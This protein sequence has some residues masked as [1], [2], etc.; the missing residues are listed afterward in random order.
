[1]RSRLARV[2]I[3]S[4][5]LAAFAALGCSGSTTKKGAVGANCAPQ[6]DIHSDECA[7]GL[8]LAVDS[9]SGFC[10]KDCTKDLKCPEGFSCDNAGRFGLVCKKNAGCD[11]DNDCPAGHRCDTAAH[12]CYI[13]VSRSICSPCEGDAQCPQGGACFT[14][15]GSGERFCTAP[16][17]ATGTCPA[18]TSSKVNPN[19]CPATQNM[20]SRNFS[21]CRYG[22]TTFASRS[23]FSRRTISA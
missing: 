3:L 9:Q 5:M 1:M 14:A 6:A 21:S 19:S 16:C 23:Y 10:T 17:D 7:D 13:K 22:L 11:T 2:S 20:P 8:C 15:K 18:L 12:T 4:L